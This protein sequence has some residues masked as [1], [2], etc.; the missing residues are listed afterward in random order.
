MQLLLDLSTRRLSTTVLFR[1]KCAFDL[2]KPTEGRSDGHHLVAI[3][4]C[5]RLPTMRLTSG[6]L[7]YKGGAKKKG[8]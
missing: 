6:S 2:K 3:T 1:L 7:A 4:N 5:H 8:L